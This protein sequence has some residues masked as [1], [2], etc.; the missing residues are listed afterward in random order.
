[1][2][3][4]STDDVLSN[5]NREQSISFIQ[6]IIHWAVKMRNRLLKYSILLPMGSHQVSIA[7]LKMLI[8]NVGKEIHGV[9]ISDICPYDRQNFASFEKISDERVLSA[10]ENFIPDSEATIIYLR[11]VKMATKAFTNVEL[12]PVERIRY[13]WEA[14]YFI[15][16]WKLWIQTFESDQKIQY[17]IE[18][19][20]IS[21]NAFAC[22]ELNAYGLLHLITKFRESERDD[23]FVPTIFNSQGCEQTFRQF[24]SMSTVNWTKINFSLSELLHMIG[25]IELQN[26]ISYFKLSNIA[27]LP[28]L[29]NRNK[30]FKTFTLPS[31]VQIKE[32]L[33]Q[34]LQ[35]ALLNANRFGMNVN[36]NEVLLCKLIKGNISFDNEAIYVDV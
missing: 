24:R 23:L 5:L 35:A 8:R 13:V 30:H 25:R 28:R 33:N 20:F 1:M 26:E 3:N 9:V 19:N 6:D 15:R 14:L 31:N 17:S 7:H 18:A 34:A 16:A 11:M 27:L 22:L 2:F 12:S 32:I 4:Q 36:A 10:L 21:S 29:H